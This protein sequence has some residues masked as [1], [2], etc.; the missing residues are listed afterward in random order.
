VADFFHVPPCEKGEVVM[1][2][3]LKRGNCLGCIFYQGDDREGECHYF[4]PIA[5][6]GFAVVSTQSW[7]SRF[8][9]ELGALSR[10]TERYQEVE[11]E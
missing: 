1:A 7:C 8:R 3:S 5:G 2:L 6:K 11:D 4:P 10:Q 9:A